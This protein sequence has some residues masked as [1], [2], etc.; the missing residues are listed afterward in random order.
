MS[1]KA[2]APVHSVDATIITLS[3]RNNRKIVIKKRAPLL[4]LVQIRC[5]G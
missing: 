2:Q 3:S 4:M 1:E 5:A